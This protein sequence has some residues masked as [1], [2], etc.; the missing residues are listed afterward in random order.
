MVRLDGL[1]LSR[2][3]DPE[4]A[5]QASLRGSTRTLLVRSGAATV[6]AADLESMQ[7]LGPSD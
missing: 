3:D 6:R 4:A 5:A 1:G 7:A 2:S